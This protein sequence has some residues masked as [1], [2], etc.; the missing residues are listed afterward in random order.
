MI[1][2]RYLKILAAI[3]YL[4]RQRPTSSVFSS[5]EVAETIGVDHEQMLPDLRYLESK[6]LLTA[7]WAG[8]VQALLALTSEGTDY[9]ES[10]LDALR[11]AEK[12]LIQTNTVNVAGNL[13]VIDSTIEQ[14]NT[15]TISLSDANV[16]RDSFDKVVAQLPPDLVASQDV[17][18]NREDLNAKLQAGDRLG[19]AGIISGLAKVVSIAKDSA[20]LIQTLPT[21]YHGIRLLFHLA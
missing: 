4:S 15:N 3:Y 19:A 8:T 12:A 9:V 18:K 7:K 20:V 10:P 5:E 6:G 2:D 21:I 16:I 14:M 17:Q 13:S 1:E 11:T